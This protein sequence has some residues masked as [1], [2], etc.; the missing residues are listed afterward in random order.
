MISKT[1]EIM[2]LESSPTTVVVEGQEQAGKRSA[3]SGGGKYSAES[4]DFF[5]ISPTEFAYI[6]FG[7]SK[8]AKLNYS[9]KVHSGPNI[10]VIVTYKKNL[11][12]F[13]ET[14]NIG[15]VENASAV[16]IE[17]VERGCVDTCRLCLDFR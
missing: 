16:N 13:R 10:N 3:Q 8:N 14:F 9:V 5:K 1:W 17:S 4:K 12:N 7:T 11:D 2:T 6:E 15:W